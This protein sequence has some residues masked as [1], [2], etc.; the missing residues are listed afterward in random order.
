MLRHGFKFMFPSLSVRDQPYPRIPR[1]ESPKP[2]HCRNSGDHLGEG[3]MP[4]IRSFA[5]TTNDNNNDN[6][7][8]NTKNT[9]QFKR[10][11]NTTQARKELEQAQGQAQGEG[12][13]QQQQ[14]RQ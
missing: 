4:F 10:N 6:S 11:N 7:N 14:Q 12:Q 13:E 8:S 2:D 9:K 5:T 1:C 3:C